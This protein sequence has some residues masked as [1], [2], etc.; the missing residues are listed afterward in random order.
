[1]MMIDRDRDRVIRRSDARL[2]V[3]HFSSKSS[4][5]LSIE[6]CELQQKRGRE[7][8]TSPLRSSADRTAAG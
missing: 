7:I 3:R 6:R 8:R 1:M 2:R 4:G 5:F